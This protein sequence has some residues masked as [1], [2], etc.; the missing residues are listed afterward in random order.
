MIAKIRIAKAIGT[1]A[2]RVVMMR[3]QNVKDEEVAMKRT[4]F[5]GKMLRTRREKKEEGLKIHFT[6]ERRPP[7]SVSEK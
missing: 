1:L 2:I 5:K 3:A 7:G 6:Y 4:N